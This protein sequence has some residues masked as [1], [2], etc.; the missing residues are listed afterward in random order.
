MLSVSKA[1]SIQAHPNLKLA[2]ELHRRDPKN[3]PDSNH[4]PEM[5][6]ALTKFELLCGFRPVQELVAVCSAIP[7][8]KRLIGDAIYQE[9]ASCTEQSRKQA[10]KRA[11]SQ[12]MTAPDVEIADALKQFKARIQNTTEKT[13]DE[14]LLERLDGQFP[15]DVGCF[16]ALFLNYFT[17]MPGEAVFLAANE[18]HAYLS[19]GTLHCLL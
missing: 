15:D 6:I 11:F 19:G 2:A 14:K 9:L 12:V 17:L 8:L 1:L 5:S 4:K 13:V 18:P 16:S 3:Y 10:L 7:E